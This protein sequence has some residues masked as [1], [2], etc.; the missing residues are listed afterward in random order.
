MCISEQSLISQLQETSHQE[1]AL[2]QST[3][4]VDSNEY[5][6]A[7]A[8]SN[9]YETVVEENRSIVESAPPNTQPNPASTTTSS[10]TTR[11]FNM[12]VSAG[13]KA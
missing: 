2:Q 8:T 4:I 11:N 13:L 9:R 10:P 12:K 3:V 5:T 6:Y 7:A 1:P